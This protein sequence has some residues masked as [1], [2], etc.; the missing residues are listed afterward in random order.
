[1]LIRGC[2]R[3]D[4]QA[5]DAGKLYDS[6]H[7][8][9]RP[10]EGDSEAGLLQSDFLGGPG[11]VGLSTVGVCPV[12]ARAGAASGR[13]RRNAL[14]LVPYCISRLPGICNHGCATAP[15]GH[16]AWPAGEQGLESSVTA[17]CARGRL[18]DASS[19]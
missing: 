4:F 14:R 11:G 17:S 7:S 1:V 15:R 3:T 18:V 2:G 19:G 10:A 6:V 16:S 8:Q 5:G 13:R 12:A 9:V